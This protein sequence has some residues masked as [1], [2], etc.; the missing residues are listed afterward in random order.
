MRK[1]FRQS[2]PTIAIA[3]SLLLG[4]MALPAAGDSH[5]E[6]ESVA[7]IY[8][9]SGVN[10]DGSVYSGI[11]EVVEAGQRLYRLKWTLDDTS[12]APDSYEG[13]GALLWRQLFVVWGEEG[14]DCRAFL[15]EVTEDGT[16]AGN[17][18]AAEDVEH[19]GW[20]EARPVG[21]RTA[22]TIEGSYKV[23]GTDPSGR[24]YETELTVSKLSP[25]YYELRWMGPQSTLEGVGELDEDSLT[26]VRKNA[27]HQ[28]GR[29]TFDVR[30]GGRLEGTWKMTDSPDEAPGHETAVRR[31]RS[32]AG[33]AVSAPAGD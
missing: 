27:G 26:V 13:Q 20:E 4:L 14:A 12:D 10:P 21:T 33:G 24:D 7:G 30:D 29:M 32:A 11:V 17:W 15:Y 22:G 28:C 9:V 6:G 18:F 31:S 1:P 8:D 3:L 16:L 2:C 25:G 23:A 5:E 19:R